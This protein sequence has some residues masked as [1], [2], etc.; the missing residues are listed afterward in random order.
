[1]NFLWK[2]GHFCVT[3]QIWSPK[4]ENLEFC[5]FETPSIF[6]NKWQY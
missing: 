4:I 1:M 2:L 6:E 5:C 3:K